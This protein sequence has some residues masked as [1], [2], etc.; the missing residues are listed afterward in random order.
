MVN[1][2]LQKVIGTYHERECKRLWP[3][4]ERINRLEPEIRKLTD[5]GLQAKTAEFKQRISQALAGHTFLTPASPEWYE[6]NHDEREAL[7]KARRAVQQR[8]LDALLPEAFAVVREAARRTVNMRHFDVQLLGG[9]VLHEGKIAEMA[10]GEGKTLVA[11]LAAYLNA[12]TGRG[13]H[14]VTVNDYL[15]R[16]DAR[17]MGPIYHALGLSVGTIQG[18]DP[19]ERRPGEESLS[20][21]YDPAWTQA[22]E[23]FLHLRPVGRREAYAADITYGQNNEFGFDYLRDNMRFRQEDL[24]QREFHYAIVDE[25]DSILIDEART[26]LIISGPAEESTDLYYR[27]DKL[28]GRLEKGGHYEVDEKEHTV[29][30][31]ED[32]IRRSEELLGVDNLYDESNMRLVHHINQALRAHE[33]FQ[34]DVEYM[35]K[36]DEIIIVDEFTGRLMPGRRWSDGLHQ[37]IEAKEGVRIRQENQTL[38]SVTF[39]NYFRMYEKLAGMTGTASTEAQE[40]SAIYR[41][42]VVAVPTNR[43]LIRTN[44]PDVV[45]KTEDEKFL[46]VV[47]EIV[48][49]FRSGQPVL[50]GTISIEKSERLSRLLKEPG[51]L[52]T[53]LGRVAQLALED[54]KKASLPDALRAQLAQDLARP[55]VLTEAMAEERLAQVKQADAKSVLVYRLEDIRRLVRAIATIRTG[56]A[57]SVLN[58]KYHEQEAQIVAQAGHKGAVT[59]ATNMAGRGTD[60]LL[61]GNPQALA[62]E[63]V[64]EEEARR[65]SPLGEEE[66]RTILERFT[67]QCAEEHDQVVA[68][69]GLHVL[70]TERHEA[71]RIDNQLRGRSGRQGDPGSSRFYLSLAD[72]LMRVFGSDRIARLMDFKWFQWEE[73]MPIEHAM[74]SKAIETAQRR[75]EGHN[76]DIRKQLLEYDNTMNRQREVIYEQRHRILEGVD[77][78]GLVRDIIA[79]VADGLVETFAPKALRPEAWNLTGLRELVQR[80]FG[81]AL[82]EDAAAGDRD[83]IAQRLTEAFERA[84]DAKGASV[85][86]DMMRYLER[87]VLL[88]V[89]DAKWKDHLYMMDALREGI[90]LRAYG[91]RDPI[92]EYQR[93]AYAM[94]QDMIATIKGESLSLLLRVQPVT[95]AHPASV[96]ARTPVTEVHPDAA[97][98]ARF[99]PQPAGEPAIAPSPAPSVR[100]RQ[101]AGASPQPAAAQHAGPKVGRNEPCPCGSGKKYKKCHGQ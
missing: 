88:S 100:P 36:D 99:A 10:T 53:R 57:H 71:R 8:A 46:A 86:P 15:A 20:F 87:T 89:M 94:F 75:V 67:R 50:I 11:T 69:G 5:A 31:T 35:V 56:L 60:I 85:G 96:F 97:E 39:Q 21:L 59:I 78:Q 14:I 84:Y 28:V 29:S 80:Q 26:P 24:S 23:R 54:L 45:Y 58:A 61:G 9:L 1:W 38:A 48:E 25:V 43:R 73:G 83:A 27:L 63:A 101:P 44:Y 52:I 49:L 72:D 37:A 76:F 30:L 79:E 91:Q 81:L 7:R 95:E 22:T 66:R 47:Q 12:L 6:R 4:V 70:G 32:G 65:G 98:A 18:M 42:D 68:R 90:H 2:L 40:F 51:A 93:E 19:A 62:T 33:L 92:V 82:A 34:R 64:R 17:W 16:R 41:L 55:A 74:V 13:V 77:L 3:I